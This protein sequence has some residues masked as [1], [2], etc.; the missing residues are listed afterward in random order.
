[1]LRYSGGGWF[2]LRISK[3]NLQDFAF[4]M[5]AFFSILL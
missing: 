3:Q 2:G 5:S 4:I 1:M